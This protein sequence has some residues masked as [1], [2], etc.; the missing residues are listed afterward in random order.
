M[1]SNVW[2]WFHHWESQWGYWWV[3]INAYVRS[4]PLRGIWRIG[5]FYWGDQQFRWRKMI[6]PRPQLFDFIIWQPVHQKMV[7]KFSVLCSHASLDYGGNWAYRTVSW[8]QPWVSCHKVPSRCS[9]ASRKI[10]GFGSLTFSGTVLKQS[11]I[12]SSRTK[13]NII[14]DFSNLSK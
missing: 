7:Q 13:T 12:C 14:L 3:S 1:L 2:N 9:N 8:N 4:F 10:K 6:T 11:Y 5:W